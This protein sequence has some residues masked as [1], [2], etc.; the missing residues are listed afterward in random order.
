MNVA[1]KMLYIVV[2]IPCP[3][4]IPNNAKCPGKVAEN[5][6]LLMLFMLETKAGSLTSKA[7]NHWQLSDVV[8]VF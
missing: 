5:V 6:R 1:P 4:K 7:E 2:K 3:L 8:P